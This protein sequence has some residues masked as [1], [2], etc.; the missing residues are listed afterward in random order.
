MLNHY[1][2]RCPYRFR[3]YNSEDSFVFRRDMDDQRT[4]VVGRSMCST[5]YTG[6]LASC[7]FSSRPSVCSTAK[8]VGR[9]SKLAG[10]EPGGGGGNRIG[11]HPPVAIANRPLNP[12]RFTTGKSVQFSM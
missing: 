7:C 3:R 4:S 11:L 9:S 12:V 8:T 6:T 1:I 5:V 10:G 2:P